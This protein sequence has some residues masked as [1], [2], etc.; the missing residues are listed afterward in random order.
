MSSLIEVYR[1]GCLCGNVR[2]E[3]RAPAKHL[4]ICHCVSCRRAAGSPGVPWAT[5]SVGNFQLT[6]GTIAEYRSSPEVRRGFCTSCGSSL[7]YAHTA[8]ESDI[9][10]TTTSLDEPERLAPLAHIWMQDRLSWEIPG[11]HLPAFAQFRTDGG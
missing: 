9:D 11:D 4:C 7:T 8:R 3:A 2:Y 10:V 5:F 6:K 1:G